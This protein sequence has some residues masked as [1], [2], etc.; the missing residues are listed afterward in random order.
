MYVELEHGTEW[1]SCFSILI[2]RE[3][4]MRKSGRVTGRA[5]GHV[6]VR[7]RAVPSAHAVI[8]ILGV[9]SSVLDGDLEARCCLCEP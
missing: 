7:A 4:E 3:K 5:I 8:A 2:F 9:T 6:H 1:L